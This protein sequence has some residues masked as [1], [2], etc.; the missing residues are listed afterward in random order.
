MQN[1]SAPC[2]QDLSHAC[3]LQ[4]EVTCHLKDGIQIESRIP[5]SEVVAR[6]RRPKAR[7]HDTGCVQYQQHHQT[8]RR[9]NSST[10]CLGAPDLQCH[11]FPMGIP[12]TPTT[13]R[14]ANMVGFST[15]TCSHSVPL[16]RFTAATEQGHRGLQT[17]LNA[18]HD[19]PAAGMRGSQPCGVTTANPRP[20]A[21]ATD[22]RCIQSSSPYR[23]IVAT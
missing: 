20:V 21:V 12:R 18:C 8:D 17:S 14:L 11:E 2:S 22:A 23:L 9:A 7:K 19:L 5:W 1:G 4:A 3:P 15:F 10:Y 16:L 6:L 13:W